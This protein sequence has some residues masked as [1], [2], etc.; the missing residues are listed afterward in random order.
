MNLGQTGSKPA[1]RRRSIRG[2]L[3]AL[4]LASVGLAVALV[5]GISAVRDGQRDTVLAAAR[6]SDTAKVMASLSADAV[7]AGDR[8]RA[9]AVI[10][11]IVLMPDVDYARIEG[12]NGA[13]LA[14]TGSG[15][16][17]TRDISGKAGSQGFSLALLGSHTAQFG[18]PVTVGG[19]TVGQVVVSGRIGDGGQRLLSSLLISLGA[20]LAAAIA[21]LAVAARLQRGISGPIGALTRS[22][23]EITD[24]HDYARDVAVAADDEVGELVDGFRRMLGE[25]RTRDAALAEHLAGLER[26]VEERTADLREAKDAAESANSAKSDFLATMSHEIRTPMNGIMVMAEMLAAGEMPPKQRRFAEVI[27]KSGS[28][29]LA[30]INDILDFSKIEA[31]KL[32]LEA[33]PVDVADVAED[34]LSLFWEKARSK[35]LDLAAFIDPATPAL[36]SGDAV[37][38]RQVVGNLVN[39]AIKFTEAGGVMVQVAPSG[40]DR[41]RISVHDTG[42]G[43]APDK[44]AGVFGA[45]TQADQSTTRKFGGSGLG[46]AICKRLVEAMGGGFKVSS[47]LGKGSVFAFEIPAPALEPARP[48]PLFEEGQAVAV[49]VAGTSTPGVLARYLKASGL[50]MA[51]L[52]AADARL[53]IADAE[54]LKAAPR[55]AA[56]TV[57][58]GEYGDSAPATL[59]REGRADLVLVQPLRRR[60]LAATLER[61]LAGASIAEALTEERA[62]AAALPTFTGRRVLVADDSAVNREVALEALSRLG[63]E[64]E[65][66]VDGREAVVATLA[67]DRFDLVLMDGSMP[68][69]DGYEATREIRR[70]EAEEDRAA[71][72]I[73][74][75]TAHVVGSAAEAWRDAGM[76]GVLH[77]PFTLA[78]LAAALGRFLEPSAAAPLA[79]LAAPAVPAA[80]TPAPALAGGLAVSDLLDPQV[81]SE[82]ARMAAMG[83]ADFVDRVRRLYRENAPEAVKGVI[84]ASVAGDAEATAR[85][86]HALKSMSLNMGARVVAESA[87]RIEAQAR[88]LGVVNVDQAQILHRQL[89]A[90]LDVLDGYPPT[91]PAAQQPPTTA[92][93][94]EQ[95]LLDDL[96]KAIANDE[97]A[98]VYQPQFDRDG[99]QIT[100]VETLLR[101]NHPVRGFVSPALFIPLAERHGMIGPITQWVLDR[102]MTETEGLG[103]SLVISFNASAVEFADPS[104]V[105]ELSVLIARRRFDPRRLEIEVTETAVLAEEDEVRRNMARLHELGLK[106]ALDDFGVGYSSLS[107]L[108][109]FPFD[110]LKI[111][112]AFVTGCADNVQSAT[113]V[114]AVVAIGRSLGM[115]VVAEGV[116]TESQRK[117]LK[118]A[119][120]HAMQGYLFARPE[121]IAAL[122]ARLGIGEEAMRA[123]AS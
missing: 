19:R 72:P 17:L 24:S 28:S 16:R 104:F 63:I 121:P 113:L 109:L 31:G 123:S 47:K 89:L 116:E 76:D 60:E 71:T 75:L 9:Y 27:A 69:M 111:D 102:A 90:T 6:L 14:E 100:G 3:T 83:K 117:F 33:A 84:D 115:K 34:V 48:W 8:P 108:R 21:G 42:I 10:R 86:A 67:G 51:G 32:E 87:A 38:L 2:K 11:S 57:C 85:A 44:I 70:R 91:Q 58:I 73:I 26:T 59:Q 5:A 118:V 78:A 4:V 79:A 56:P 45:F 106:I 29:L 94:E 22:M 114:H 20:T 23:A 35:G 66:C 62:A 68:D 37:R 36:V 82:L 110:K 1:G 49:A 119:G 122:R 97:L 55:L 74:A 81:A 30:I 12:A 101:W 7:A 99:E 92:D 39:N 65:V 54:T 53:A 50:A 18:A 40:E 15:Q 41:L 98:L 103:D 107:H 112:R 96:A 120:V 80:A 105:D 25:I 43:I 93:T 52:D 46:L 95:A 88:E 77:K 61:V 64:A 13:L